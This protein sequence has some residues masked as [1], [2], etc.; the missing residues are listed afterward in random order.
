[1]EKKGRV[2]TGI[3]AAAKSSFKY[4]PKLHKVASELLDVKLRKRTYGKEWVLCEKKK[5]KK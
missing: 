4:T 3:R 5:S 2:I 1:M